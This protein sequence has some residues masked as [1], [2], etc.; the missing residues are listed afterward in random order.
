MLDIVDAADVTDVESLGGGPV[1]NDDKVGATTDSFVKT[2]TR[3]YLSR[4]PTTD[5]VRQ[6]LE[7]GQVGQVSQEQRQP[8]IFS[9][10]Q[11]D[12]V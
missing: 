9:F 6:T 1:Y 3:E 8:P 11:Q 10:Q 12:S 5:G 7:F 2:S 4:N